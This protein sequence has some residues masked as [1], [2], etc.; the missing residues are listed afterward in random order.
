MPTQTANLILF[1][2]LEDSS[3]TRDLAG[4]DL[5]ALNTVADWIKTFVVRP[6]KDLGRAGPVCPFVPGSLERKTLWFAPEQIANRGVPEVVQLVNDYKRLLLRTQPTEGDDA[7]YKAIMI[8]FTDL[9]AD[10]AKEYVDNDQVQRLKK[11]FYAEDGVV[12]GEFHERNELPAIYNAS[13]QPFTPPVP[14]LLLRP[15]VI[16]DWKF[17]VGND[18]WLGIWARRFGESAVKALAEE[19]RRMNWPQVKS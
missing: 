7:I 10:H 13:F 4:S 5:N 15:A 9:S 16:S 17:F 2:D 12:L 11:P 18:D 1:Q 19:L 14:F 8:V 3:K 6:N